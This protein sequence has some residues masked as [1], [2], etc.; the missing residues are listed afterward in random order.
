MAKRMIEIS[1]AK[2]ARATFLP[3]SACP[4]PDADNLKIKSGLV[5]E[6]IRAVR[7]HRHPRLPELRTARADR[8]ERIAPLK[9]QPCHPRVQ[10]W[11]HL[12]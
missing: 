4:L 3:T 6:I 1:K 11:P 7:R 8:T 5:I 12:P 9:S 2:P 10:G